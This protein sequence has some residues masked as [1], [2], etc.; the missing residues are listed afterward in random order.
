MLFKWVDKNE[1]DSGD[2]TI[3]IVFGLWVNNCETIS[4]PI[5]PVPPVIRMTLFSKF[6]WI[7]HLIRFYNS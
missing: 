5:E 7:S 4:D 1:S 2:I 3:G 6:N